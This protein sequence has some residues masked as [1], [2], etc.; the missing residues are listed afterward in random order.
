M[1]PATLELA[2]MDS[3]TMHL[4]KIFYTTMDSATMVP[5]T[6]DL[7]TMETA[8]MYSATM[9]SAKYWIPQRRA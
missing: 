7:T 3:A 1:N 8:A 6:M 5:A 9:D 4:S 2:T